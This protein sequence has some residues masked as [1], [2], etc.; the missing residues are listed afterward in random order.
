MNKNEGELKKQ[1]FEKFH[2][3]S[4]NELLEIWDENDGDKYT[5]IEFEV[6]GELL[7]SRYVDLNTPRKYEGKEKNNNNNII[8]QT[9]GG[10]W[11]FDKIVSGSL[12]KFLYALG[13][14]GITIFSFVMFSNASQSKYGGTGLF[15][16]GLGYLIL[17]NLFWRIIC[18]GIIII[19]KIFEKLNQIESKLK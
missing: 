11:S 19:F 12:I 5:D 7:K 6:I 3:K 14:I 18:E 17:G 1:A 16:L 8:Q 4:T 13:A 15:L 10:F 9:K 2:E